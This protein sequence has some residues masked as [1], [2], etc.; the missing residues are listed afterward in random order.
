MKVK[1]KIPPKSFFNQANSILQNVLSSSPKPLDYYHLN[2]K[3]T[4]DTPQLQELIGSQVPFRKFK[5]SAGTSDYLAY[6]PYLKQI[7]NDIKNARY[8]RSYNCPLGNVEAR[9]ALTTME[10]AK[11]G[12]DPVY[13]YRDIALTEGSTG[14]IS[15]I[16][17]YLKLSNPAAEVIIAMPTYYLYKFLAKFF[18]LKYQEAFKIISTKEGVTSFNAI[19]DIFKKINRQ[20]KL[21]ILVQPNNPTSQIYPYKDIKKLLSI[22]QRKN[23]LLLVD[24]LFSELIFEDLIFTPTDLLAKKCNALNNLVIVKGYSKSKNLAGFRIGYL[25]SK[26]K[27]LLRA[28]ETISEQRQCFAAASNFTG[29]IALDSFIQTIK[30]KLE[31]GESLTKAIKKTKKD[32]NEFSPTISNLTESTLRNVYKGY[33]NYLNQI[34]ESYS[35]NY[36]LAID[37]LGKNISSLTPKVSA[38]NT[39]VKIKDMEPINY[40][41]FCFNF[42][43]CCN[44]VTQIG[45]CFA[46]DQLKWQKDPSLGFWLRLSYS[47]ERKEF[48]TAL[49]L[50]NEF[51]KIYLTNKNKFLKIGLMF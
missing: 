51:K 36:D 48:I 37:I 16:F 17:E 10:N 49:K 6:E 47:R 43:L 21:I 24:E 33:L 38:F 20:T 23:I 18:Q 3:I 25:F 40:F 31:K 15:Q 2:D 22:C 27:S 4:D 29:A 14:A 32:F 35:R 9:Q 8:Y 1:I 41:D 11:F 42:Y 13:T 26:N 44:I 5:I 39:F 30:T 12:N 50:F 7:T 34:K 46:F 28:M 19:P 45:P